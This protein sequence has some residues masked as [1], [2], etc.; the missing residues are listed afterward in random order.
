MDSSDKEQ[1]SEVG[2]EWHGRRG[3]RR[4]SGRKEGERRDTR[5]DKERRRGN[6]S[7]ENVWSRGKQHTSR[8]R[9]EPLPPRKY[10]EPAQP[11]R[12]LFNPRVY[13]VT[14]GDSPQTFSQPS[15]YA[16]LEDEEPVPS[17]EGANEETDLADD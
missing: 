12:A 17:G 11:V 16:M 9:E 14:G 1:A 13:G 2:K 15:R 3:E 4:G 6:P 10:E 5:P 7:S 8:E